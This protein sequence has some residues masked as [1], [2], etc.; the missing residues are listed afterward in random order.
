[1]SAIHHVVLVAPEIPHNTG[2]VGRL[3]LGGGACLHLVEP[4]GFSLDDRHLRRCGLDYWKDVSVQRWPSLEDLRASA[5]AGARF[6]FY[7]TKRGRS[8]W[9][10]TYREGDYHVFGCETRGLPEALL[11]READRCRTIPMEAGIRSLNLAT[12]VAVVLFEARR[13]LSHR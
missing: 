1:M 8:Y 3:C 4:L 7:T 12:S 6:F 13:Q 10:T 9:D 2:A 5:P 11:R